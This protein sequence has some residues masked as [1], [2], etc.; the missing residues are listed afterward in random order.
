MIDLNI[1]IK[2]RPEEVAP[3]LDTV[4]ACADSERDALGFIPES[5]YQ[6]AAIQGKLW[7]ATRFEHANEK[8]IGH[9]L[10]GGA[11]PILRVFQV[12]VQVPYRSCGVGSALLARLVH[13][14]ETLDYLS[15]TAKVADD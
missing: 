4:R 14:A 11:F 9:V 1:S 13:E 15:V 2:T 8:Y 3:F 5:A 6:D 7:I 12:Y 10:F